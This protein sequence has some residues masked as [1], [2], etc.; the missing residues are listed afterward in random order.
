MWVIEPLKQVSVA[1][2]ISS[3]LSVHHSCFVLIVEILPA[4]VI[5]CGVYRVSELPTYL[6]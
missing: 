3:I 2:C 5:W 1:V 6:L 4:V